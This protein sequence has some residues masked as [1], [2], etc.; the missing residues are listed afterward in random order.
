MITEL[1]KEDKWRAYSRHF[2]AMG[3]QNDTVSFITS[4]TN[5]QNNN[6]NNKN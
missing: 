3:V 1:F 6:N 5:F 2:A 4:N